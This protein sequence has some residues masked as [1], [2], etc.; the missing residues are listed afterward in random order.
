MIIRH[1]QRFKSEVQEAFQRLLDSFASYG[2][3]FNQ[4]YAHSFLSK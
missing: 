4:Q 1:N 3:V 2:I